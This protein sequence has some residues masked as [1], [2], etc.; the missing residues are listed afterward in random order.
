MNNK[1]RRLQ[2][3]LAPSCSVCCVLFLTF[4][5]N[6]LRPLSWAQEE[7]TFSCLENRVWLPTASPLCFLLCCALGSR[8]GRVRVP[9][10]S[11]A[12]LRAPVPA[13]HSPP[14]SVTAQI[15]ANEVLWSGWVTPAS[16]PAGQL[17]ASCERGEGGNR[18]TC[19]CISLC[20]LHFLVFSAFPD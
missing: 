16:L 8:Q 5:H 12:M 2:V 9:G 3:R 20:F 13:P 18:N 19:L 14:L 7:T 10:G 11:P 1:L 17:V 4:P 6:L 15:S